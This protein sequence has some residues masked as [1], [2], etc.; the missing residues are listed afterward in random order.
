MFIFTNAVFTI[1]RRE[2]P[3]VKCTHAFK[4]HMDSDRNKGSARIV[5]VAEGRPDQGNRSVLLLWSSVFESTDGN[6]IS[7]DAEE[8]K[9]LQS[10]PLYELGFSLTCLCE[11]T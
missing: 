11:P 1:Y 4:I 8:W 9:K 5:Q 7:A 10:E 6:E 2:C 3:K